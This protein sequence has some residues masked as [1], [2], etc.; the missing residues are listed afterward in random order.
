MV[1]MDDTIRA[2]FIVLVVCVLVIGRPR[3]KANTDIL[4]VIMLPQLI[5]APMTPLS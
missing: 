4:L 1:M 5:G 2:R 3:I